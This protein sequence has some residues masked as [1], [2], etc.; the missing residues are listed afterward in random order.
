MTDDNTL[1]AAMFLCLSSANIVG[2]PHSD[3][4]LYINKVIE[5]FLS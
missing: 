2:Q 5:F 3:T 4:S 1:P